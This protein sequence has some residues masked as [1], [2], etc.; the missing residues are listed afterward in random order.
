MRLYIIKKSLVSSSFYQY[1]WMSGHR[2]HITAPRKCQDVTI[3]YNLSYLYWQPTTL[4]SPIPPG[5]STRRIVILIVIR[6]GHGPN[7]CIWHINTI[8]LDGLVKACECLLVLQFWWCVVCKL[9]ADGCR[10]LHF[11]QWTVGGVA[12]SFGLSEKIPPTQRTNV[13][14]LCNGKGG[15]PPDKSGFTFVLCLHIC[16][17]RVVRI[18]LR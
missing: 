9:L 8:V 3:L 7:S 13:Q 5:S 11:E 4:L 12:I 6:L 16:P 10:Y 15:L 17:V 1:F 2:N 14:R 18:F